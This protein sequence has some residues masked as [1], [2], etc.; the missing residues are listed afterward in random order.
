MFCLSFR[1]E[2]A[3]YLYFM[4]FALSI[5]EYQVEKI[6][7]FVR[8]VHTMIELSSLTC[9]YSHPQDNSGALLQDEDYEITKDG[10]S[11]I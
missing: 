9:C 7:I 10:K 4:S 2:Q 1:P 6:E 3:S 11:G 5:L 8:D